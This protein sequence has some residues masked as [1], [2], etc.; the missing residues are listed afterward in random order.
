MACNQ[1][2][3]HLIVGIMGSPRGLREVVYSLG[4]L[5]VRS[6]ITMAADLIKSACE[7]GESGEIL[8]LAFVPHS[9]GPLSELGSLDSIGEYRRKDLLK[10]LEDSTVMSQQDVPL[11]K[12]FKAKTGRDLR[13]S[14]DVV[15]VESAG[16]LGLRDKNE[17]AR[18]LFHGKPLWIM[19]RM[20]LAMQDAANVMRGKRQ[21]ILDVSHGLNIYLLSAYLAA[22]ILAA[23]LPD[24]TLKVVNWEP[25]SFSSR[26]SRKGQ[27]DKREKKPDEEA[28]QE[29][30]TV[31]ELEGVSEI[32]DA[33]ELARSV[34]GV[35]ELSERFVVP[36]NLLETLK[37]TQLGRELAKRLRLIAALSCGLRTPNLPLLHTALL[38]LKKPHDLPEVRSCNDIELS[39]E[40]RGDPS[41]PEV[42][43]QYRV[44]GRQL[45]EPIEGSLLFLLTKI[46]DLLHEI[47]ILP[48]EVTRSEKIEIG[49][50]EFVVTL[51]RMDMGW[52]R[53]MA[54]FLAER[55][56][57]AQ[58][59]TLCLELGELLGDIYN[60]VL[61]EEANIVG[62]NYP[63]IYKKLKEG[64]ENRKIIPDSYKNGRYRNLFDE[65]LRNGYRLSKEQ[66]RHL[67]A[68]AGLI[69]TVIYLAELEGDDLML[70]YVKEIVDRLIEEVD[71]FRQACPIEKRGSQQLLGFSPQPSWPRAAPGPAPR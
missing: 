45:S 5:S 16:R 18:V 42:L 40:V 1:S 60:E 29:L 71:L 32:T 21:I 53:E 2:E 67:K 22:Q 43:Y 6:K 68:H 11:P 12:F 36:E 19:L 30:P 13:E 56:W 24:T 4:N 64:Q 9:L 35:L 62:V 33:F 41:T 52:I 3:S 17:G 54:E 20:L 34:L 59:N 7:I 49:D 69:H 15:P 26:P 65:T 47:G 23:S 10:M 57:T 50:E 8:L 48:E 27:A 14:V 51:R 44:S 31:E 39:V 58:V 37:R 38:E 61:G 70:F 63:Q 55:G 46:R 28:I 66:I 25:P